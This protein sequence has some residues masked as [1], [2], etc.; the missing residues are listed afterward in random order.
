MP[1]FTVYADDGEY[2][3]EGASLREGLANFARHHPGSYPCAI[4]DTAMDPPLVLD[5]IRELY[6]QVGG[7]ARAAFAERDRAEADEDADQLEDL[8][9]GYH[10]E[11]YLMARA[12]MRLADPSLPRQD[13]DGE[14]PAVGKALG[15]LHNY[16]GALREV[17]ARGR[18]LQDAKAA[19]P[20]ELMD[21]Y[22]AQA[23]QIGTRYRD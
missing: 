16:L 20:A 10:G 15:A 12:Q 11:A 1:E 14:S 22:C 8:R 2:T 13:V 4:A 17:R 9:H 5:R 19:I 7:M 23:E 6:D 18:E 21:A 3:E